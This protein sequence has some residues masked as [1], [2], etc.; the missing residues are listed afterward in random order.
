M[1]P[2][3]IAAL[4][5]ST[6][7]SAFGGA[8]KNKAAATDYQNQIDA[9]LQ[10]A[11][12]ATNE[13]AARNAVLSNQSAAAHDAVVQNRKDLGGALQPIAASPE[14]LDTA[15]KR[16]TGAISAAIGTLDPSKIPGYGGGGLTTEGF[17]TAFADAGGRAHAQGRAT[18]ELGAVGD[19]NQ[20][21]GLAIDNA[22]RSIN[23][24]NAVN[25]TINSTLSG[26]QDLAGFQTR[27]IITRAPPTNTSLANTFQSL[28]ALGGTI[29]GSGALKG[30]T[31]PTLDVSSVWNP[32]KGVA[33]GG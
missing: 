17:N 22:N 25:R 2:V 23:A 28:G 14:A 19:V 3:S 6:A 8:Q 9:E 26:A 13:A 24:T 18:A 10:Q 15:S 21:N 12:Q 11:R 7:L 20:D 33:G 16:R 4:F 29:A 31:L 30:V 27:K 5:G 1:D 32:I